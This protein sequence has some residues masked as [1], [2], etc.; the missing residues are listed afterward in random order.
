M[1]IIYTKDAPEPVGPYSQGIKENG[2][3]FFSGQ[4]AIN[5]ETGKL[6]GSLEEQTEMICKNIGAL[7]KS[8]NL[9]FGDVLKT[10]CFLTE[11]EHFSP[12]N[13]IYAE[14]FISEPARS[15]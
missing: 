4:I 10:T 6:E 1:E 15:C 9:G 7:L 5:P 13:E 8:E 3:I 14:Y 12:F 11:P 2:F